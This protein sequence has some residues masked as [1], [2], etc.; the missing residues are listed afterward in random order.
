MVDWCSSKYHSYHHSWGLHNN[1]N[2]RIS[3][4]LFLQ[5][6]VKIRNPSLWE[7][8]LEAP[9]SPALRR[10]LDEVYLKGS[11]CM[12]SNFLFI[13]DISLRSWN[14]AE[15]MPFYTISWEIGYNFMWRVFFSFSEEYHFSNV[16]PLFLNLHFLL[17]TDVDI[18]YVC[19][20]GYSIKYYHFIY[21]R[22]FIAF[23]NAQSFT[24]D[25]WPW[26]TEW[27]RQCH[28]RVLKQDRRYLSAYR[29]EARQHS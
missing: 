19:I 29:M 28:H 5:Y 18:N 25:S 15:K 6:K 12:L 4:L 23:Y 11:L 10:A 2:V 22:H 27:N 3:L 26:Q 16:E 14:S 20:D 21:D 17:M 7:A 24:W 9:L 1:N 13:L 8:V